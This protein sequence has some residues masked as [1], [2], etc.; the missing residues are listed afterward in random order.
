MDNPDSTLSVHNMPGRTGTFQRWFDLN[1]THVLVSAEDEASLKPLLLY[2]DELSGV[3]AEPADFVLNI[4]N[5]GEQIPPTNAELIVE[6]P[7]PEGSYSRFMMSGD[8]R[9]FNV[10]GEM[11][12]A[13]CAKERRGKICLRPGAEKVLD[14][15]PALV[16]VE[17][18]LQSVGQ[19]LLHAATLR[20]PAS[21]GA[22]A[23]FA[24]SG[25]GKTTTSLALVLAGFGFLTDD[26]TVLMTPRSGSGEGYRVWG[27]PRALKVHHRTRDLLP[28]V[29]PLLGGDWNSEGEKVLKRE[30]LRTI[31]EVLPPQPHPLRAIVMLE[32]RVE[33][34]HIIRKAEKT[35]V[36]AYLA[37][38]NVR[39]GPKGMLTD[40]VDRFKVLAAAIAATPTFELRVGSDLSTLSQ[41]LAAAIG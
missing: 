24:R 2:L 35:D 28:Q 12:Y 3:A 26:A 31:A 27:L 4:E 41:E 25:A 29:G 36:M 38:D 23:L 20:L 40:Q 13:I 8:V 9:W 21:E 6:G 39:R 19:H 30:S 33:G 15:T 37:D 34:A 11:S 7:L 16:V 1:G 14:G 22:L 10:P 17:T 18:V 32:S 5:C